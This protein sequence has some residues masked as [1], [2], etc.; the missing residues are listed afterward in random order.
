[1]I[2]LIPTVHAAAGELVDIQTP[3]T[4]GNFFGFTCIANLISNVVSVAFILSAIMFFVFL[5]MGGVEWISSG[6]DKAK[7]ESAQ[8]RISSALVGLVIVAASWAIYTLVLQ[9]LGIDLSK[10]CSE[11]PI[12]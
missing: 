2:N 5:V 4:A 7:V 10:I 9:F 11:N 8:K 12:G 1:M 3:A 6:G